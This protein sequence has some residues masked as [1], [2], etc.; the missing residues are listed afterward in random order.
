RR[1]RFSCRRRR[2]REQGRGIKNRRIAA[3][4]SG[5]LYLR[6][7]NPAYTMTTRHAILL[8]TRAVLEWIALLLEDGEPT[9]PTQPTEPA[10]HGN[11]D[12]FYSIPD[13]EPDDAEL[14]AA[15]Q[16]GAD[17]D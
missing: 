9:K 11:A 2:R 3:P 7:T 4:E 16:V 14:D 17:A 10:P 1:P 6:Q 15:L 5:W 12:F 8:L 13:D